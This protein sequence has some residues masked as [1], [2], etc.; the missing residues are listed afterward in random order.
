MFGE[1]V[2]IGEGREALSEERVGT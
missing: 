1:D 2:K